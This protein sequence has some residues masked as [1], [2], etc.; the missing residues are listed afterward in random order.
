MAL[1]SAICSSV[2]YDETSGSWCSG[3]PDSVPMWYHM[4]L[5]R[6]K[7]FGYKD[8][9]VVESLQRA[10][11]GWMHKHEWRAMCIE[12]LARNKKLP[13]CVPGLNEQWF[14]F[15]STLRTSSRMQSSFTMR[16]TN[17]RDEATRTPLYE[18]A[19]HNRRGMHDVMCQ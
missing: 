11:A 14:W 3:D 19:F 8:V 5:V 1:D 10:P 12:P 17:G 2:I 4:Q 9:A 15:L 13:T 18:P 16:S 6:T 7:Q